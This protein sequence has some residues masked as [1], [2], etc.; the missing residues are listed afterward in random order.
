MEKELLDQASNA[1][2]KAALNEEA[3]EYILSNPVL[4]NILKKAAYRNIR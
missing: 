3:K 2:R 1:L 4:F